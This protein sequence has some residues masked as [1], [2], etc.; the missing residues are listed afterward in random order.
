[1]AVAYAVTEKDG[2]VTRA[3]WYCT[4]CGMPFHRRKP[5]EHHVNGIPGV[6]GPSCPKDPANERRAARR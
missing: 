4:A 6:R 1:V 3:R 2:T 5:C